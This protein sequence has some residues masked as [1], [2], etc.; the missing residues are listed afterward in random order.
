MT[1]M[2]AQCK[3]INIYIRGDILCDLFAI[4][5]RRSHFMSFWAKSLWAGLELVFT[6]VSQALHQ[7]SLHRNPIKDLMLM[8]N[9]RRRD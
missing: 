4:I 1:D 6:C 5:T 2:K 7:S 9:Q 3:Y 8:R